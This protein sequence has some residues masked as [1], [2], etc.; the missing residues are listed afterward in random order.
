MSVQDPLFAE[1]WTKYLTIELLFPPVAPDH[2]NVAEPV[3][4]AFVGETVNE[5]GAVQLDIT[6][7]TEIVKEKFVPPLGVGPY[8]PE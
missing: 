4:V 5:L 3:G 2:V 1:Y 7:G 6:P 8:P